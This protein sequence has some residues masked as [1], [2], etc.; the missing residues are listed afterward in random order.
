MVALALAATARTLH[1]QPQPHP[2]RAAEGAP[3]QGSAAL[4]L[5]PAPP[6]LPG[7]TARI[8][9][10]VKTVPG[11]ELP[12][13]LTPRIEGGAV[14]LARGRMLRA[15]GQAT[16]EGELRFELPLQVRK[17]GT[18]ILRVEV[19]T[20]VCELRCTPLT[21]RAHTILQVPPPRA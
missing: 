6:L 13:M 12:L 14:E 9:V 1:A 5:G 16:P 2:A 17:P 20:H 3:A 15:D 19:V 10:F 4:R 21:L 8:E 18:A 7:T 11:S